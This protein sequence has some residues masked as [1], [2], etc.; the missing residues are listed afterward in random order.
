MFGGRGGGKGGKFSVEDL[1]GISKKPKAA[2]VTVSKAGDR[3]GRSQ[4][5]RKESQDLAS[6]ILEAAHQL[7]E[8]RRLELYLR[9]CGLSLTDC[10]AE[11]TA[12]VYRWEA[13]ITRRRERGERERD[14]TLSFSVLIYWLLIS[15]GRVPKIPYSNVFFHKTFNLFHLVFLTK[16]V[17][18]G[19]W[20]QW[21]K[22][23]KT[24]R[25]LDYM[26]TKERE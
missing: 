17:V 7:V 13:E 11:R 5:Q 22:W 3:G 25:R 6:Q 2:G 14:H 26:L 9:E 19:V 15:C 1:Y 21:N 10:E 24:L 4:A 23:R 16:N 20:I 8:R 18:H 12:M